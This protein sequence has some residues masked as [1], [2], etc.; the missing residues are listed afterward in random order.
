MICDWRGGI[1][2]HV[3]DKWLNSYDVIAIDPSVDKETIVWVWRQM[4]ELKR[5]RREGKVVRERSPVS[6]VS[7][8]KRQ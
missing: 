8:G 1:Y 5:V 2:I 6:Q 3:Q 4:G 7:Q